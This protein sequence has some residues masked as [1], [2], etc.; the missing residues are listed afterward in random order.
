MQL[1]FQNV[2]PI[3]LEE[4]NHAETSF[5]IS[6]TM[7]FQKGNTYDIVAS[8]GKGKTTILDILFGRRQD[9]NGTYTIDGQKTESLSLKTWSELRIRH[10]SYVF[11]GLRLFRH[12]TGMQNIELK[13]KLTNH[14][15]TEE[16]LHYANQLQIVDQLNKKAGLMSFGQ[17]Q[18]LA[19]IRAIAQPFDWLLL[20]EPFSHIDPK[21]SARAAKLIEDSCKE[22]GAGLIIT[23]LN[24]ENYIHATHQIVL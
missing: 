6:G 11:Q 3:P 7:A 24:K 19:I 18:R 17:Q 12:L 21:T 10:L 8:S 15:S 9:Y 20:D 23:R 4:I 22:R 1:A 13:N 14:L 16:I 2:I 5:W